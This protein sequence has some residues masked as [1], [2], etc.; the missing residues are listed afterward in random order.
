M[1]EKEELQTKNIIILDNFLYTR[2]ERK[3][4]ILELDAFN[5]KQ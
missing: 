4:Q 5:S 2:E 3:I 1:G